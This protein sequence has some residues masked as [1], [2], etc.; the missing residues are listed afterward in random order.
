MSLR[1]ENPGRDS[2]KSKPGDRQTEQAEDRSSAGSPSTSVEEALGRAHRHTRHSLSEGLAA[3][4]SFIEAVSIAVGGE[5]SESHHAL[6]R[7]ADRIEVWRDEMTRQGGRLSLP[8][9]EGLLNALD[10][11]VARWEV[12]ARE[13]SDARAVMRAFLGLREVLW[14]LGVRHPPAPGSDPR[15]PSERNAD[16]ARSASRGV[17]AEGAASDPKEGDQ[18]RRRVQRVR[19]QG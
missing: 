3:A 7:L 12:R 14:E 19:V 8:L 6:T 17:G 13:D 11:E 4:A 1:N 9:A 5:S 15:M 2:T 16:P 10:A 18:R